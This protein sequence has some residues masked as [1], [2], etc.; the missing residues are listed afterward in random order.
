[1]MNFIFGI[2]FSLFL[3]SLE[4]QSTAYRTEAI[5]VSRN[6]RDLRG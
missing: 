3:F 1:M 6:N 2:I 5:N 4:Q